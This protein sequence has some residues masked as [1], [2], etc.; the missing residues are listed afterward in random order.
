MEHLK[1]LVAPINIPKVI[2]VYDK[3]QYWQELTHLCIQYDEYD[4]ATATMMS[5]SQE[6]W[7]H[8]QFNNV[9]VKVSNV[10]FYYEVAQFYLE[11]HPSLINDLHN[12]L[13][14]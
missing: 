3:Q 5:H 8:M 6:A 4:N 2:C 11:E 14:I 7:D 12:V 10:E 1:L 13:V 9:V